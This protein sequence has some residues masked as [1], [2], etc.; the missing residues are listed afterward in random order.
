M[1]QTQLFTK[2]RREAP[3]GEEAK[4]AKLL[5]RAGFINKEMAGVYDYLPLGLRVLKRI[6]NLIREE[7]NELGGQEVLMSALQN[8][9]LWEKT[10]RWS[11]ET[12]DNW[13]KTG[14]G[15][16]EYGLGFTHEEPFT[17]L[18]INHTA[19]YKDL[20]F[21]A[22]QFQNKFRN[23]KRAKSGILRGREFIMKDLYSFHVDEAGLDDFYTQVAESYGRIFDRAGIG[24]LTYKTFAS[25]GVFSKYSH[26]FQTI[27]DAGEDIVYIDETKRIAVNKEVYT[28]EVLADLGLKKEDLIEKKAI[29]T[30]NIFKLGTRFSDT[31]G[32]MYKDE[33]GASN[34]VVMGSYGIGLGRLMGTIVETL[35]DDKGIVWP[36]EITPFDYHLVEIVSEN[37][38]VRKKT[39]EIY[40]KLSDNKDVLWDDRD[41]RAGEKF[42]DADLIGIPKQIIIGEKGLA[43]NTIEIKD[44]KSGEVKNIHIDELP[45]IV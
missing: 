10:K 19:S 31:L 24:H 41:L 2:T 7:M 37:P 8:A 35:S 28:D 43:N 1:R 32:L 17:A 21:S 42:A 11:S 25:G 34:P 18:M 13:F 4:N 12:V 22:Y 45:T 9:T 36:E 14:D 26:E 20:P 30:G 44:R 3:S 33:A 39:E 29:E 6:E 15:E 38:E 40:K 27:S 23:E 5:I 16:K